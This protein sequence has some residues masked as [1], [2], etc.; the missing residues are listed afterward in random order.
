MRL[1]AI[2]N[3]NALDLWVGI[4][5]LALPQLRGYPDLLYG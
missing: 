3:I 4:L 2:I 5:W 1:L